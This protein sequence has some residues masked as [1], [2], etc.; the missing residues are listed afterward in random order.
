MEDPH[1]NVEI[2]NEKNPIIPNK[3]VNHAQSEDEHNFTSNK[4]HVENTIK[5]PSSLMH[6]TKIL[7]NQMNI[8]KIKGKHDHSHIN[9]TMRAQEKYVLKGATSKTPNIS[10]S[11][12]NIVNKLKKI[13]A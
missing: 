11:Q 5:I 8:I 13:L 3:Q 2:H 9:A 4:T 10:A 12:Y 7:N 1:N 6:D